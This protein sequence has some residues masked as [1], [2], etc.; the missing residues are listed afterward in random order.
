MISVIAKINVKD[1]RQEDFESAAS[2]LADAVS[3]NEEG[4][5]FYAL[6]RSDDPKMYVFVERY[7]DMDAVEAHRN[8]AHFKELAPKM[9]AFID[10]RPDIMRVEQI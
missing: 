3:K 9:G 5:L 7:T 2:E 4:C 1:G 10:G 6:H 8:S